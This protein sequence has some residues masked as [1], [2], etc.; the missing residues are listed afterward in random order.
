MPNNK[1]AIEPESNSNASFIILISEDSRQPS[2][3]SWIQQ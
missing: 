1:E 3:L 2:R